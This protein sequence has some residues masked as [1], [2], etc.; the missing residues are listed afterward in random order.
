MFGALCMFGEVV[1]ASACL[2]G[3]VS[4][5]H[6][7]NFCFGF[8]IINWRTESRNWVNRRVLHGACSFDVIKILFQTVEPGL[9][10]LGGNNNPL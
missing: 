1:W 9:D 10:S 7:F 6:F 4:L 2:A 3:V 8:G 5:I